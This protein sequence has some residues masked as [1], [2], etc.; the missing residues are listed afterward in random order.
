M[1]PVQPWVWRSG[2][3]AWHLPGVSNSSSGVPY[4]VCGR[5]L[6]PVNITHASV[7]P[8]LRCKRCISIAHR[9]GA[10]EGEMPPRP[11]PED[12]EILR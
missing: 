1:S 5:R 8:S 11:I 6:G 9:D 7:P 4:T 2:F 12:K 10:T 3:T